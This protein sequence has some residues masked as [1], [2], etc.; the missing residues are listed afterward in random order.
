MLL[1][2]TNPRNTSLAL[3]LAAALFASV[4]ASGASADYGTSPGSEEQIYVNP[5]TGYAS[6]TPV[7]QPSVS[8]PAVDEAAQTASSGGFD[9]PSAG[10]GAAAGTALLL[11][12]IA[13]AGM[14]KPTFAARD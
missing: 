13:A 7:V 8:Q 10:I 3:L 11:T 2:M 12:L 5:S 9:W 6:P 1:G 4:L 14:R